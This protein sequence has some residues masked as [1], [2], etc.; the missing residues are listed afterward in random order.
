NYTPMQQMVDIANDHIQLTKNEP[1][2]DAG[3]PYHF[4]IMRGQIFQTNPIAA[5]TYGVAGNNGYTIHVCVHGDYARYDTLTDADLNALVATCIMLKDALPN[6][7]A[8]K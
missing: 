4:Y 8:I 1:K 7:A 2:G 5:R 6:F 3:F